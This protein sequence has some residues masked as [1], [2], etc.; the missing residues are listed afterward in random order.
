MAGHSHW[1]NIQRAKAA[2]DAK[3]GKVWSKLAR[4]L[5]MAAKSGGSNPEENLQLRYAIDEAKAANMPKNTIENA[6]K[7]GSGELQAENYEEVVYEGYGPCGVAFIVSCLTDNRNRTAPEM[8]KLFERGGG[9]L[10]A[11]NCVGW[12]FDQKGTFLVAAE[13]SDEDTLMEIA[14][15]AGADDVAADTDGFTVTCEPS[16]FSDVKQALADKGIETVSAE[17]GLVPQNT[18]EVTDIDKARQCVKLY[19]ALQ[20]H[21]DAQ[22]VYANFDIPEDVTAQLETA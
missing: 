5:I 15:E 9:Q 19:E 11:T 6:I 20:D 7:K 12:M 18:V 14:L 21:D 10:G 2:N 1:A 13:V 22:Q 16:A 4:R 3:R 8:R 17:V